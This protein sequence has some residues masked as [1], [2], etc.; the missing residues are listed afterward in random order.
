MRPRNYA[1]G[2]RRSKWHERSL[3]V[4]MN[5]HRMG[6]AA[7]LPIIA[8]L[9]VMLGGWA[10]IAA[11]GG[12][13]SIDDRPAQFAAAGAH[14]GAMPSDKAAAAQVLHCSNG[15]PYFTYHEAL[16]PGSPTLAAL[17]DG[18]A[19][20]QPVSQAETLSFNLAG[21]ARPVDPIDDNRTELIPW[22]GSYYAVERL[23]YEGGTGSSPGP[24]AGHWNL[25]LFRTSD[26]RSLELVPGRSTNQGL[27]PP[28]MLGASGQ[29]YD[30]YVSVDYCSGKFDP[31]RPYTGVT[32]VL[33]F[34]CSGIPGLPAGSGVCQ[35]TSQD[36]SDPDSWSR[37]QGVFTTADRDHFA[38]GYPTT[39][40]TGGDDRRMFYA[41]AV[42]EI[43]SAAGARERT[44]FIPKA[45]DY[46]DV[47][48]TDA[49]KTPIMLDA[50][51][52]ATCARPNFR[53]DC[54]N[55]VVTDWKKEGNAW[56]VA[57]VGANYFDSVLPR[58]ASDLNAA[59]PRSA[60]EVRS[61]QAYLPY[62]QY[63]SRDGRKIVQNRWAFS[64]AKIVTDPEQPHTTFS[65]VR[66]DAP[67]SD[68]DFAGISSPVVNVVNGRMYVYYSN[69][70]A[71]ASGR[72]VGKVKRSLIIA[73]G[74]QGQR[75][76]SR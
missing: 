60:E 10:V 5:I 44:H 33:T 4:P 13:K 25:F 12:G 54:N 57:Y 75:R 3:S 64:F 1:L 70:E 53:W 72:P 7:A 38:A 67:I 18:T 6:F 51:P 24:D 62:A 19:A 23:H 39:L 31:D 36:I 50:L 66:V 42:R 48:P 41:A 22:R 40:W 30:P 61:R 16:S 29:A 71:D 59:M 35:S 20:I 52:L 56:Y 2:A 11:N 63:L 17:F 37:P 47:Q 76:C 34:E 65:T 58:S 68:K 73:C 69:Y 74:P 14:G 26:G 45:V 43:P 55:R 21:L 28:K 15:R 8:I 9:A 27:L 32:F 49:M 46:R